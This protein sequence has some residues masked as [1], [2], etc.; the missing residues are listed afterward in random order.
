M[1]FHIK[2]Y[3]CQM[4]ERESEALACLLTDMGYNETLDEEKADVIILNTCSVR[5][6]AERK[7]IGK[8]GI[9][10]RLLKRNPNLV[11]GIIGCM[12]QNRGR[13]LFELIPHLNFVA[14]T[15]QLHQVPSLIERALNGE[16]HISELAQNEP[17]IHECPGHRRGDVVAMTSVMRGCN[18][19]C[20]YCIVPHTR[21][22]ERSREISAIVDEVTM[23]AENGTKEILL[24]GQ[25][26]TAY[27]I[28]EARANGT[29]TPEISPFADLLEAI[30]GIRG[31]ERIR[32][33]SPHVRYM[34]DKFIEAIC[35][36][37][38]VCKSFHIP[39][40]S[41]SDRILQLM[42]RTYTAS[43]F[44]RRVDA[45]K[46][47]LPEVA[48]STDVIVG[49][50]TE[51]DD[52]F[53]MTRRLMQEIGF[54]MA[55]IFR[56]S[57]REGTRSADTM[58]DDVSD[59]VKHE[60][61]QILLA[62]LEEYAATRNNAFKGRVLPVLVEGVSKRNSDKWTGRSDLNKTCNF[63]SVEGVRPGDIVGF[64]VTR[65]SAN[66]LGGEIIGIRS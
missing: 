41:G 10:K 2:T 37:P 17:E 13:Q 46:S 54:D 38:K 29:Y 19:F 11:T 61:N 20:T 25:N 32:F 23:L 47:R 16:M 28:A 18:Q 66:S 43:D 9:L 56:Y 51:T 65:C 8:A 1:N 12:A 64:R 35:T 55:Y 49:F 58:A 27:G 3:G 63:N 48:F 33:T 52:D 59:S 21:G 15:E 62:D 7:A 5:E 26:I 24:L 50:P 57:P 14:G 45:I 60:R 34:N 39:L 6:Q 22:R 53:C 44:L 31:I 36:L 30:N 4:N 42:H 40:Q